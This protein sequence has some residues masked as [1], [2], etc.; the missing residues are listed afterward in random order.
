MLEA[1]AYCAYGQ[2]SGNG[3]GPGDQTRLIPTWGMRY[4]AMPHDRHESA[5]KK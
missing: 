2:V 5:N 1:K 4:G 3:G